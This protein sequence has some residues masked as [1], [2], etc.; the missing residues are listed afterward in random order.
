MNQGE[1]VTKSLIKIK[2]LAKRDKNIHAVY[3]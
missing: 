2:Y 1:N 3:G